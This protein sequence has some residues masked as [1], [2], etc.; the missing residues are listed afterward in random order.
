MSTYMDYE[1]ASTEEIVKNYFLSET[2]VKR[3]KKFVV[4]DTSGDQ[5]S[6][7]IDEGTNNITGHRVSTRYVISTC[8]MD[9]YSGCK[10]EFQINQNCWALI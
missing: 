2:N 6:M 10:A 5:W 7:D 9:F 8:S 4:K 3:C 1:F